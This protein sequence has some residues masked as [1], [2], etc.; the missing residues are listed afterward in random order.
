M[1]CDDGFAV[2]LLILP[3]EI[4]TLVLKLPCDIF[5]YRKG[6]GKHPDE[7]RGGKEGREKGKKSRSKK[8]C[9][10]LL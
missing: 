1:H 10:G 6:A 5:D 4:E 7:C 3:L 8:E 2:F 9:V